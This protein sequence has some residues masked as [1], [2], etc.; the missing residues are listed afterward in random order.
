MGIDYNGVG[1]VGI[2]LTNDKIKK[3]IEKGVFTQEEWEY[4]NDECLTSKLKML[5]DVGGNS[6]CGE[7]NIY[8]FVPGPNL[9]IVNE[10]V[11]DF[12]KDLSEVGID[13]TEEDILIISDYCVW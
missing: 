10:N 11:K 2:Q 6:Y 7:K 9:K 13:I 1:G 12:I 4:D 5:Y 8:L 3:M